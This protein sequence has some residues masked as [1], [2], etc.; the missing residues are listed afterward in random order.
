MTICNEKNLCLVAKRIVHQKLMQAPKS[1]GT[2]QL[3]VVNCLS[4]STLSTL[5]NVN[6]GPEAGSIL[7]GHL[8]SKY[9]MLQNMSSEP[10]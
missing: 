10:L 7:A 2:G 8:S 1:A 5:Q 6:R 3:C 4:I 9:K